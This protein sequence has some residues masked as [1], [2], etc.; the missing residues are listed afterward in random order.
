MKKIIILLL[1]LSLI[2]DV[3]YASYEVKGKGISST[4][5]SD[6]KCQTSKSQDEVIYIVDL[7]NKKVTRTAVLNAGIKDG[8]L[9]GMQADNTVYNIVHD[10]KLL[11]VMSKKNQNQRIVKAIGMAGLGDGFETIV[12][13]EDFIDTA[14][15]KFD[16]FVLYHYKRTQ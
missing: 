14:N 11:M 6:G 8:T 13:G 16:Y 9:A 12:I 7:D 10:D 3:A 2:Y 5:Y 15:S 4:V 1:A